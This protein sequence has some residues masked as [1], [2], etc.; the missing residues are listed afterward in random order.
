MLNIFCYCHFASLKTIHLKRYLVTKRGVNKMVR[1]KC[2]IEETIK[3]IV[4]SREYRLRQ[5]QAP[6]TINP[7]KKEEKKLNMSFT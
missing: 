4:Q 7:R 6:P 5:L 1:F 3:F 2:L